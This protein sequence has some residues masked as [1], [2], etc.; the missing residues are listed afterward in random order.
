M[1]ISD[2]TAHV[3]LGFKINVPKLFYFQMLTMRIGRHKSK[4]AVIWTPFFMKIING[5][6]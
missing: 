1:A 6:K 2:I 5:N 4:F 3:D